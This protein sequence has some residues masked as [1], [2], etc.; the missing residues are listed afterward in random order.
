MRGKSFVLLLTAVMA[1]GLSAS[2]ER[3]LLKEIPA[4]GTR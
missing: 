3:E 1:S 4:R 2:G